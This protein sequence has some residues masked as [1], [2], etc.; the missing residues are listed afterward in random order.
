M[1]WWRRN[2]HLQ[3]SVETGSEC[4]CLPLNLECANREHKAGAA[5]IN[6]HLNAILLSYA[7][8]RS[9]PTEGWSRDKW[10]VG[11]IWEERRWVQRRGGRRGVGRS[12]RKFVVQPVVAG[13]DQ[14]NGRGRWRRRSS[15]RRRRSQRNRGRG[16]SSRRLPNFL[17]ER[18]KKKTVKTEAGSTVIGSFCR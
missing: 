3:R 5:C 9:T 4:H 16:R 18:V 7:R 6:Q 17:Q 15:R 2:K 12:G 8:L 10:R 14:T 1:A 11:N 13:D